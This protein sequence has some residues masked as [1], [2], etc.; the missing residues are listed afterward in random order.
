LELIERCTCPAQLVTPEGMDHS[1]SNVWKS[2]INP[3]KE[4]FKDLEIYQEENI[5]EEI[6]HVDFPSFMFEN[7]RESERSFS[8]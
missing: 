8:I 2:V 7:P 4:F 6:N 1:V 3:L 5:N